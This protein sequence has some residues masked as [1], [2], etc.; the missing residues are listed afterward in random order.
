VSERSS[1]E[2]QKDRERSGLDAAA[3]GFVALRCA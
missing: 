2:R 1:I 3:A